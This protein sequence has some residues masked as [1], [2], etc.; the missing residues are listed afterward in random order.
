ML[1]KAGGEISAPKGVKIAHAEFPRPFE[2]GLEY[3]PPARGDWNIVHMGLLI[4][5]SH[6]IY[7]CAQGCLRGVVQTTAEMDAMDRLS[8][9]YLCDEDYADAS[10]EY[11]IIDS[12]C[13]V[14]KR[15]K[16]RPPCILVFLSCMHLFAGVD[17]DMI[18][19]ELESR[20]GGIDFVKCYMTP[21]MRF[22][23]LAPVPTMY[24]QMFVPL[25]NVPK[26]SKSVNIIGY[27]WAFEQS[28]ELV[29]MIKDA[30]FTL[31]ELAN[32]KDYESYLDMAKSRLNIVVIPE[33]LAAAQE[34]EQRI[35]Q[36]QLYLPVSYDFGKIRDN[37]RKLC[38]E[39]GIDLP[40]LSQKENEAASALAKAAELVGSM[41]VAVDFMATHKPLELCRLLLENGFNVRR[42]F[43]DVIN[44][45]DGEAFEY[46]KHNHP[47]IELYPTVNFS[48]RFFASLEQTNDEY[49]AIGQKAAYFCCTD[50]FV[51]MVG[52]KGLYGFDGIIRLAAQ[53]EDAFENKKDR[54]VVIQHKGMGCQ[55][56]L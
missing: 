52:A 29:K 3:S 25:R 15:M 12:V 39:L 18:I 6:Q 44:A 47:D 22:S 53:I 14:I 20:F 9:A 56:C 43:I 54:K 17:F 10:M 32:C 30:G 34:L 38:D 40:D 8:W 36:K 41:P 28:C 26:D 11:N 45:E 55:S 46:I 31:R 35:G 49:L 24:K 23:G 5:R 33:A 1:K 27:N 21:T 37:Y 51:D 13:E 4:P 2:S 16:E 7:F 19:D 42:V 50:H 48:M